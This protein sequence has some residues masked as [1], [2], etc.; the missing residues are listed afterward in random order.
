MHRKRIF[1]TLTIAGLLFLTGSLFNSCSDVEFS[2]PDP[3][4][5]NNGIDPNGCTGPDCPQFC[6]GK[7]CEPCYTNNCGEPKHPV[8]YS[9]NFTVPT[10]S[11]KADILM[12]LDNSGSMEPEHQKLAERLENLVDVLNTN[13]VD[14]QIC[15][16]LTHTVNENGSLKSD[17][18]AIRD[19]YEH[20][21]GWNYRSTGS[22][23]LR[24]DTPDAKR[25]FGD[26][27]GT[28]AVWDFGKGSGN[29]QAIVAAS[30]AVERVSSGECFRPDAAL[31]MVI[32][33]DEDQKSCGGR[34]MTKPD[35][36]A[37]YPGRPLT[38]YTNQYRPLNQ[39]DNPQTLVAKIQAKWPQKPFTGHSIS[40]LRNDRACY[41]A[42]DKD[43]PAFY[44]HIIQ[45][46]SDIT[47]GIKGNICAADYASQLTAIGQRTVT[48]LGSVTLRCAPSSVEKIEITPNPNG[49]VPTV[50]GD[51]VYFNPPLPEGTKVKVDYTC[52][53]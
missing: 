18:G 29:E 42:Q 4:Q 14:W 35:E 33:T 3:S 28:L 47:D 37:P 26:T 13:G 16:T 38:D 40:I 34:C 31:A 8:P 41:D 53:E 17:A 10:S 20:T 11:A 49:S 25:I 32:V 24:K 48:S 51:K 39:N 22:K 15:Y 1:T 19:W 5:V 45:S 12:I 21:V 6:E 23:V 30:H 9:S 52:M 46:L 44:G 2:T 50:A 27:L 7:E 43:H 36:L